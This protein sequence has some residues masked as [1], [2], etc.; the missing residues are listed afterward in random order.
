MEV[1]TLPNVGARLKNGSVVYPFS[2]NAKPILILP[3][4]TPQKIK[5]KKIG[6]KERGR[7]GASWQSVRLQAMAG[8]QRLPT[9]LARC[10]KLLSTK[11]P[12]FLPTFFAHVVNSC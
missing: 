1:F 11:F 7:Q 4:N 12:S 8:N 10:P 6:K 9:G 5:T 2:Q 3:H